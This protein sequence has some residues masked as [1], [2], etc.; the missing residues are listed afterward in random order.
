MPNPKL[1]RKKHA[2]VIE[3]AA[4]GLP[5]RLVAK[6]SGVG[7]NTASVY[8]KKPLPNSIESDPFAEMPESW[9]ESYPPF[10][11]DSG[12]RDLV[13]CDIHVPFHD[14]RAV[15]AAVQWGKEQDCNR[16]IL[17]GDAFD[18][19]KVSRYPHDGSAI[20]YQ[21]EIELGR[22]FLKYLR[23]Q[24]PG[25]PIVFKDGNHEERLE[26]YI[27]SRA[28][29]LFGIEECTLA[30]LLRFT[31]FGVD[32]VRD[33]RVIQLGKLRIIHGHEYGGGVSAP[34]NAARWLMNKAKKA[35]L[36]GHLHQTSEQP[37]TDIDGEVRAC[38]SVGCLSSLNPKYRRLSSSWNQGAAI[39]T[40]SN[41]GSFEV[42]N[43][44][45]R[46]GRVM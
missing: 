9:A 18:F 45:I 25:V 38:W 41:D 13:L 10:V 22:Q 27:L 28:E 43:K 35:S 21:Q 30:S 2:K 7:L 20:T 36:M 11:L 34:V 39:I 32:H 6:K 44:R 19:H 31:A 16:V 40:T 29:A 42:V 14:K 3:Y 33:Q 15:E 26:K 46:D 1:S 17:D 12:Y 24:F 8:A 23:G 5:L 37:E 4:R